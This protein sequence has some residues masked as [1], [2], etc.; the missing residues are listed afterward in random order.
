M[1]SKTLVISITR[2]SAERFVAFLLQ[3]TSRRITVSILC[4]VFVFAQHSQA[5]DQ[6]KQQSQP[7]VNDK[8]LSKKELER[9]A[10]DNMRP[11]S[12]A[13]VRVDRISGAPTLFTL[14]ICDDTSRCSTGQLS[15]VQLDSAEAVIGEATTFAKTEEGVGRGK[16][17]TTRFYDRKET[18]F[19]VDVSKTDSHS[20]FFI[21]ISGMTGPGTFEAGLL[22]RSD[23]EPKKLMI[24]DLLTAIKNARTS[25]Q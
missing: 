10:R 5:Q 19:I 18:S 2:D 20:Q 11:P 1:R 7:K 4:G 3:I 13:A 25:P 22:K 24:S 9:L 17:V 16:P 15:I 12:G 21:T 23:K 6:T 8:P 14:L